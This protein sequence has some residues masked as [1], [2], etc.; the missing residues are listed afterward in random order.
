MTHALN[1]TIAQINPI[2]GNISHNMDQVCKTLA[3]VPPNT[4]ILVFPEMVTCGYPP[5]DLVLKPFFMKSVEAAVKNFVKTADTSNTAVILPTPWRI[6]GTLYNAAL[7]IEDGKIRAVTRKYALPNYG[8]FDEQRIFKQ[9][10]L[11]KPWDIKGHKIGVMICED[12]WT[13]KVAASLK[14]KG[15]D[16]LISVN[17]SPYEIT[18]YE[19]RTAV[20]RA[21][22]KETGLP[23][24]CVNQ[25][26]GQDELVFDGASFVMNE[27]GQI[28]LQAE[29]FVEDQHHTVWEK[30]P[31]HHWLCST[32]TIHPPHA[33][34][35]AIYQALMTGLRD[36]VTKNGFC[37]VLIGM[38]GGIDSALVA[39]L[40][41]DALGHEAVFCVMMPSKFTSQDSLEDAEACAKS[42]G[43]HY[44][45]V[46]IEGTVD[47]LEAALGSHFNMDTPQ[48]TFENLQSRSRGV[49]LM[50]MSNATGR[51]VLSTGNKSEMAVGYATLYGDMCGGFNPLK[52]LYK[53]D[54]YALARFRNERRPDHGLGPHGPVIPER[55][56]TKPPSAELR[57]DQ[58]DQDSLPPYD[59]LDDILYS[60]IEQDLA[61][62]DIVGRGHDRETVLRI[63]RLLDTAE[64]KRRQSPPGVKITARSFGRDRR[65]PVTN[66]FS[67]TLE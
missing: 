63:W 49:I 40:A 43:A 39:A 18:K 42:L 61:I 23:L 51:M 62:A 38:S 37:G 9:G 32:T 20:A 54:V 25:C 19:A 28:V 13:P 4:D 41:V 7:L 12:M 3:R 21:R 66:G 14:K 55:I 17:A 6:R 29:E 15:A 35:E 11:P 1:I 46:S 16:M 10:P 67:R 64:Y 5:E 31:N 2:V 8:V 45:T 65:Y 56:L 48:I 50:A 22:V 26:G 44:E 57:P 27:T 47:A 30:A 59:V 53:T 60:L 36:Y 24:V 58:T 34:T 33:H 52:D